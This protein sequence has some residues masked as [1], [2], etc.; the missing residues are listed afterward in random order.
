M[1]MNMKTKKDYELLSIVL[2][3][4]ISTD[5]KLNSLADILQSPRAIYGIGQ[6]KQ[7]KIYALK[8]ILERLL[9]ADKNERII[10]NKPNEIGRAHV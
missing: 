9:K 10:I 4:K 3:L 6:K 2:G 7:E 5:L 8:E 1:N